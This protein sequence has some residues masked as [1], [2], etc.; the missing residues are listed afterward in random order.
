MA[1]SIKVDREY[2][3]PVEAVWAALTDNEDLSEWLKP[4]KFEPI[5]GYDFEFRTKPSP[6][7]DGIVSC[8]VLEIINQ[9]FLSFSWSGGSLQ[10]TVVS[11]RISPLPNNRTRLQF[12]HSGF[13][14]LI[15]KLIVRRIL[16][17]GWKHKILKNYLPEYLAK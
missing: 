17:S 12:E 10:N 3:A 15:N 7:F 9:Q 13:E 8:K 4:C 5:L 1:K 6:G 16:A 14:G 2:D 11:F